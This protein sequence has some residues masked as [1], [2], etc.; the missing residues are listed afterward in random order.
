MK[1]RRSTGVPRVLILASSDRRRGAEVFTERLRDG[2]ADS[3][4]DVEALGLVASGGDVTARFDTL[5]PADSRGRRFD[6]SI[7]SALRRKLSSFK[8]DVLIA[9][10]GATLRYSLAARYGLGVEVVYIGIG[11]PAYWIRSGL[12]RWLNRW[13]LRAT[14]VVVAVSETTRRQLIDLEPAVAPKSITIHTG[15]GSELTSSNHEMAPGPLRVLMVGSLSAEKDPSL[16]L[17]AVSSVAQ[18]ELRYVGD[19][20]LTDELVDE[21]ARLGMTGRVHFTGS[22]DDVQPHFAWA[23]VLL[24]TSVTEGL[25][26]VILE[27]SA[28]GVPVVS[29]DVG[30]VREAVIDGVSGYVVDRDARALS[31]RLSFLDTNRDLLVSM[32]DSGRQNIVENF[33]LDQAIDS[34]KTL[35]VDGVPSST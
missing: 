23:H 1:G 22:V 8:P 24:L 21:A 27:A 13:M 33:Q 31:D 12:S 10:G 19:G 3:G 18:A 7:A 2:L 14:D 35:L 25:P 17:R 34:Y 29:V 16:A 5:V 26:G 30:G 6:W 4:W 28:A 9:N 11:E 32:G 20:P 15:V